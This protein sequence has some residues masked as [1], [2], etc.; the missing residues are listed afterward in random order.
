MLMA[1][2]LQ[3]P[4]DPFSTHLNLGGGAGRVERQPTNYAGRAGETLIGVDFKAVS[5]I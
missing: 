4:R 2:L 5:S 3:V 1:V